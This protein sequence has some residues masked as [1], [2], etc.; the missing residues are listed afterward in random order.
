MNYL[1]IFCAYDTKHTCMEHMF[2][3]KG[4]QLNVVFEEQLTL[5]LTQP[6]NIMCFSLGGGEY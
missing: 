5:M 2:E 4:R 3:L 1:F 6:S